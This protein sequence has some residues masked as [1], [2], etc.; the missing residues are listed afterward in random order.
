MDL[1][2]K[3]FIDVEIDETK[4]KAYADGVRKRFEMD[5]DDPINMC[6]ILNQASIEGDVDLPPETWMLEDW[7][8][9]L[10]PD[11]ITELA[12]GE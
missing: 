12:E 2:L 10:T 5:A 9:D 11:D 1:R 4:L 6:D 7:D 3:V 8:D